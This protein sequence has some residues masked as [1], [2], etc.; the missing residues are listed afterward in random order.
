MLCCWVHVI[1]NIFLSISFVHIFF[2]N[3]KSQ[4][5]IFTRINHCS[6]IFLKNNLLL[7]PTST[8][9]KPHSSLDSEIYQENTRKFYLMKILEDKFIPE[10][11]L[12]SNSEA[13]RVRV[14]AF[15]TRSWAVC[16]PLCEISIPSL[17]LLSKNR[18][19][20]P[21]PSS[22]HYKSFIKRPELRLNSLPLWW[23]RRR[24]H[25]SKCSLHRDKY[26]NSR[27]G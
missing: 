5:T 21:H 23:S 8:V 25:T 27:P 10:I 6:F 11:Q 24:R 19:C 14:G 12:L 20:T 9:T 17:S 4:S 26:R 18:P 22:I 13:H 7:T 16:R 3:Y 2:W 1:S 15:T